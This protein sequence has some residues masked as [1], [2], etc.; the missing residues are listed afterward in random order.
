MAIKTPGDLSAFGIAFSQ[1]RIGLSMTTLIRTLARTSGS[2]ALGRRNREACEE[3]GKAALGTVRFQRA[4]LARC[5]LKSNGRLAET[6]RWKRT[7]PRA[8]PHNVNNTL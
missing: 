5:A 3:I 2:R 8:A 4:G 1:N 6:A 7:V